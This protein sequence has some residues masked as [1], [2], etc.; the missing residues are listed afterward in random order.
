MLFKNHLKQFLFFFVPF[1]ILSVVSTM[2]LAVVSFQI[3]FVSFYIVK[4]ILMLSQKFC[5]IPTKQIYKFR[6]FTASEKKRML[7]KEPAFVIKR[8]Q[9]VKRLEIAYP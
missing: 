4:D 5:R 8:L 1:K 6:E 3:S 7:V 2:S 9:L